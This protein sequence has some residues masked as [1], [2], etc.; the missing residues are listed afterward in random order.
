MYQQGYLP[1]YEIPP[2]DLLICP[3]AELQVFTHSLVKKKKRKKKKGPSQEAPSLIVLPPS[4]PPHICRQKASTAGSQDR[5]AFKVDRT[6]EEAVNKG[7]SIACLLL[8]STRRPSGDES[9]SQIIRRGSGEL[10]LL[11]RLTLL[12][13]VVSHTLQR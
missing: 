3:S 6:T 2:I 11:S 8:F 13:S 5:N 4:L 1:S 10:C 9:F 7:T 12:A